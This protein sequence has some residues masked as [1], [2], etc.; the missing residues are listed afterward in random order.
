MPAGC[1]SPRV[2][3]RPSVREKN[4]GALASRNPLLESRL[5]KAA[6]DARIIHVPSRTG[7]RVPCLRG[8]DHP[9]PLHSLV[10]PVREGERMAATVEGAGYVVALGLGGGFHLRPL[11]TQACLAAVLVIE[12]D[13]GTLAALFDG[14]DLRD[15]LLD[16]RVTIAAGDDLAQIE[17]L[18]LSTYAPL[19]AGSL[20]TLTLRSWCEKEKPFFESAADALRAA[21]ETVRADVGTQAHF[22][23]RWFANIL[24]NMPR[25]ERACFQPRRFDEALVTAAG[26]SLEDQMVDI[27][28]RQGKALLV[29]TDTSLP[30]LGSRRIR[31]D[32]VLSIDCQQYSCNHFM[33]GLPQGATLLLDLASPPLLA[34]GMPRHAFFASAHPLCR[35]LSRR[36]R[37]FAAVD[38]SGGNVAHAAVSLAARMGAARIFLYGA[39]F[40]CPHGK[41]YARGTYQYEVLGCRATRITPLETSLYAF[42]FR[43]GGPIRERSAGALLYT[44]PLLLS[45]RRNLQRLSAEIGADVVAAQGAGLD[46]GLARGSGQPAEAW[47]SSD[48]RCGW[49]EFLDEYG[50]GLRSLSPARQPP[51]G[52]FAALG[53]GEKELWAT[54][55]PIAATVLK[56]MSGLDRAATAAAGVHTGAGPEGEA[57]EGARAWALERI[58]RA[59]SENDPGVPDK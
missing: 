45:Y 2:S 40:S 39:D 49:R 52:W 59:L 12:K 41:P 23:K 21:V 9:F 7:E 17:V 22:G 4:L 31:P 15:V 55:L 47:P 58:S 19:L 6:P 3:G 46:L 13:P 14:C 34:R 57:L 48:A 18:L 20:R 27:A 35:F 53:D 28:R 43:A 8:P 32:V 5:R 16:P 54:I 50:R 26:P 29:A 44:T 56:E 38:T 33:G 36:W 10:D 1:S 11:L 37:S 51:A 24:G 25:A 42:L 30:A